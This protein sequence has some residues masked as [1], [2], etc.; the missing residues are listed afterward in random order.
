M[1]RAFVKDCQIRL[2]FTN[3]AQRLTFKAAWERSR[4]PAPEYAYASATLAAAKPPR[5]LPAPGSPWREVRM[6]SQAQ[7]ERF[8][9]TVA[10]RIVPVEPGHGI[11]CQYALGEAVLYR[12]AV[13]QV[14]LRSGERKPAEILIERRW[15]RQELA[16]VTAAA[17][18]AELRAAYPTQSA[19]LMPIGNGG[20]SRL[21]LV[22][23]AERNVVVLYVPRKGDDSHDTVHPGARLSK[24]T[25]FIL[26]DTAWAFVKNPISSSGRTLNQWLQWPLTLLSPRLRA[27]RAG[28]PPVVAQE[29][30]MDLAAWERWLD[31]HTHTRQERGSMRLLIDGDGF[32]PV[33]ERRVREAQRSVSIQV[34][35]LTGM[36]SPWRL[37]TGSKSVP[38]IS[39]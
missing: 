36:T 22:D 32:F 2:H 13:G 10:N 6:L 12:D 18:E 20:R 38:P 34:S 1:P 11:Y 5:R 15:S 17:L 7:S 28:I 30:G 37:P 27:D 23:L 33:L 31:Q 21:V 9:R 19:F 24:L 4:A 39:P 16:S 26:I 35:F 29:P 14:Q 8:L 3:Q 25:S